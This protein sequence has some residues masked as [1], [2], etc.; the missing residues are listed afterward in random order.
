MHTVI[1]PVFGKEPRHTTIQQPTGLGQNVLAL[2]LAIK[3]YQKAQTT[4]TDSHQT[5]LYKSSVI[6]YPKPFEINFI[7]LNAP[8]DIATICCKI[9]SEI[10]PYAIIDTGS[11][12]SIISENIAENLGIEIDKNS[13]YEITGI[14]SLA[15]TKGMIHDLLITIG[16]GGS[17]ITI[18]DDFLVVETEKDKNGKDKSLLI[19][20]VPWQYQVGWEPITKG[21]FK[22]KKKC[23]EYPASGQSPIEFGLQNDLCEHSLR[24][25][26]L[27]QQ[28][29]K[30]LD[31]NLL[32]L[33]EYNKFKNC[34]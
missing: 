6:C 24:V 15:K 34:P 23:L 31:Y 5:Q 12:S 2:N 21:K 11:D 4:N 19:L 30:V 20:G 22:I 32:I 13:S 7:R 28:L 26:K 10:M 16:H 25:K 33:S 14:A 17:K 8:N 9:Y 18:R 1:F 29:E 3:A 27:K